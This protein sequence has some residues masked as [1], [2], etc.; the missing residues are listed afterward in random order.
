MFA[1][2]NSDVLIDMLL[3]DL[4]IVDKLNYLKKNCLNYFRKT[5]SL[6]GGGTNFKRFCGVVE[7]N[8]A[9]DDDSNV[10]IKYNSSEYYL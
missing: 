10:K 2:R 8:D 3:S 4:K 7:N 9:L 5:I 1:H 6:P